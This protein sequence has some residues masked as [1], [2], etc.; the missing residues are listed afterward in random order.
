MGKTVS[1]IPK[2]TT[3]KC[4]GF[5]STQPLPVSELFPSIFVNLILFLFGRY[6]ILVFN[7]SASTSQPMYNSGTDLTYHVIPSL[8]PG[9]YRIAVYSESNFVRSISPTNYFLTIRNQGTS[10]FLKCER[11]ND[12]FCSDN[13]FFIDMQI[14]RT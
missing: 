1:F 7:L 3:N 2:Y 9:Q 5:V 13:L 11:V 6:G 4:V 8:E 14:H 12:M 10:L